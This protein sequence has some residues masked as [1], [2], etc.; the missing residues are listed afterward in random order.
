MVHT[1]LVQRV[2]SGRPPVPSKNLRCPLAPTPL[3]QCRRAAERRPPVHPRPEP[4]RNPS[5][6]L[7]DYHDGM[8]VAH[9]ERTL[10]G[11]LTHPLLTFN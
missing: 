3:L 1:P 7:P 11:A 6:T 2:A 8:G 9:P 5:R 10:V 4:A